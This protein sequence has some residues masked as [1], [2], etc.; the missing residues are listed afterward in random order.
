MYAPDKLSAEAVFD[1]T[2]GE[3]PTLWVM[4]DATFLLVNI[5]GKFGLIR[6][7]NMPI[8]SFLFDILLRRLAVP[9]S[10]NGE[11]SIDV[12][13]DDSDEDEISDCPEELF[14][15]L[16]SSEDESEESS[17]EEETY[18]APSGL[19]WTTLTETDAPGRQALRNIVRFQQNFVAALNP[20]T[21][22]EAF[23]TFIE[24]IV[25]EVVR[26]TNLE[27][28]RVAERSD[29]FKG[30]WYDV[31]TIEIY[32]FLGI[33]II[34]GAQRAQYRSMKE[35][36]DAGDGIIA[37]IATMSRNRFEEIQ[38]VLRFDDKRR[39]NKDDAFAPVRHIFNTVI[40]KFQLYYRP[41][42]E[43]TIDEQL[44]EFHGRV[45]FRQYM[46]S[47][48]GKCGMKLLLLVDNCN[49]YVLNAL[50]YIGEGTFTNNDF[51]DM[52]LSSKCTLTLLKPYFGSGINVTM[53][54]WFSSF[55]LFE[56]L[57]SQ[58]ITAVGTVRSNRRDVPTIAK[59]TTNR[60]QG[61]ALYFKKD[62][63]VLL[64]YMDRKKSNPVL[65]LST[66]H[67]TIASGVQKPEIVEYYNATKSGVD[68]LDH[69]VRF[70]SSKRKT[71]RWP[72]AMFMNLID[73]AAVNSL[74]LF[75][76]KSANSISRYQ[77]LK[78]LAHSLMIPRMKRRMEMATRIE[79][80]I[81]QHIRAFVP[82]NNVESIQGA[83]KRRRCAYCPAK[84]GKKTTTT[85]STCGL[86]ICE[87]HRI[88]FCENCARSV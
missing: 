83:I 4:S 42:S 29:W 37:V 38:R 20:R 82:V 64:S 88:Q 75:K 5:D 31:D 40:K 7:K 47:K 10:M 81:L 74:I 53:D 56:K 87:T 44:L 72:Y 79:S 52:N 24:D 28:R 13:S 73:I 43:T 41:S 39:R 8:S 51:V 22:K 16:D 48:P 21:P 9:C 14:F 61:S 57:K 66:L 2:C 3:L 36:Y 33:H 65:L 23:L 26:F 69:L 15:Q 19:T 67:R 78:E 12:R 68:N 62:D 25:P 80:R 60:Q 77:F 85:C 11:L 1:L 58:N 32:A 70:Y 84:P 59:S 35:I 27:A 45:K 55:P 63:Q 86:Y 49:T 46:P 76:T 50:P 17:T 6:V 54:N 71:R 18:T 34:C 30:R